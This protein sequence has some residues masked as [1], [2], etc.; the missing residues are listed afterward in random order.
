M[1]QELSFSQ[2]C[3]AF[4]AKGRENQF[5]YEGKRALF[6]YLVEFEEATGEPYKLD[7]IALC[8]EFT[9]EDIESFVEEY[10]DFADN[11]E[12]LEYFTTVIHVNENTIIYGE[13]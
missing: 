4:Q 5:S 2:F 3:D 13:F 11:I 6:D 12:Q 8:C 7:V 9:E 10:E 1:F